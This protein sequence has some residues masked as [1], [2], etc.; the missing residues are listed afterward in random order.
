MDALTLMVF[1]AMF[2]TVTALAS[3]IASMAY[4]GEVGHRTSAQWMNWRVGLQ[5]VT[6][7]IILLALLLSS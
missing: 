7:L 6:F 4:D 1:I 3:G 2:A 5:A